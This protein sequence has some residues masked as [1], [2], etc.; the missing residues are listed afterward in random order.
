MAYLGNSTQ[1]QKIEIVAFSVE[2]KRVSDKCPRVEG[3]AHAG[4]VTH[5]ELKHTYKMAQ[6]KEGPGAIYQVR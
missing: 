2:K 5:Y 1:G 4:S 3:Y 6:F